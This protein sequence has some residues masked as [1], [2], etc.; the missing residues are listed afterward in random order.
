M[1]TEIK[2]YFYYF[3]LQY[4]AERIKITGSMLSKRN[5]IFIKKKYI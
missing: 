4:L 3:Q 1:N 2:N 5:K